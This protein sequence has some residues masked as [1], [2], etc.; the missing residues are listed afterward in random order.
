MK[1]EKVV[2]LAGGRGTRMSGSNAPIP[3]PMMEVGGYPMLYHIMMHYMKYD[4]N[5]FIISAGYKAEYI[6][7]WFISFCPEVHIHNGVVE[8]GKTETELDDIDVRIV[9]TGVESQTG[10]RIKG[11]E[12]YVKND[13][14]FLCTY[15]DGLSDVN[16]SDLVFYH[17]HDPRM[18]VTLTT[19]HPLPRFGKIEFDHYLVSRFDEKPMESEWINGGFYVMSPKIFRFIPYM[20]TN[21]EKE[22]L[23]ELARDRKLVAFKHTGF[24]QCAD[25]PR[26]LEYLNELYD[27]GEI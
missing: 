7:N 24:W 19:V 12:K 17:S 23:P 4:Y 25:T 2:I 10:G 3:K 15:G 9:D 26:D 18:L 16:I 1:N 21:F 22:V 11:I 8:F 6:K 14:Y 5:K 27:K 20:S 13:D